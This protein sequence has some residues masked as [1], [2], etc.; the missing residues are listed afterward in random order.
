LQKEFASTIKI[1]ELGLLCAVTPKAA[2]ALKGTLKTQAAKL[3]V[4]KVHLNSNQY[5]G[6][7]K[8]YEIYNARTG[9]I[10]K[11]GETARGY[12]SNGKLIRAQTQCNKFEQQFSET[13]QYRELGTYGSKVEVRAIETRTILER[14]AIDP[15]ALPLNKGVH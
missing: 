15:N 14:R 9:Q 1:C 13:F 7:C 11:I 6:K 10:M 3:P 2:K 4:P 5:V 8:L 12:N